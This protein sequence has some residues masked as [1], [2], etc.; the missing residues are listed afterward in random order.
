[1]KR[2]PTPQQLTA[3]TTMGEHICVDAGAGSGK[4][5]VLVDRIVHLLRNGVPL[6]QIVAITFTR[7]AAAEMR[8]R[9]RR[10]VHAAADPNDPA[11]MT[12]WRELEYQVESARIT[13]IDSFCAGLL[14]E[15]ALHLGIDPDFALLADAEIGLLRG[16]TAARAIEALLESGD[17]PAHRLAEEFGAYNLIDFMEETL[18]SPAPLDRAAIEYAGLDATQLAARWQR[19]ADELERMRLTQFV[20][21]PDLLRLARDLGS[22]D[23]C[24]TDASDARES[25]RQAALGAIATIQ[26]TGN[27]ETVRQAIQALATLSFRGGS[28]KSWTPES[29]FQQVKALCEEAKEIAKDFDSIESDPVIEARAAQL[30]L[31]VVHVYQRVTAEF[32]VAKTRR[33]AMDFPDL[34]SRTLDMLATRDDVRERVAR[35]I[36][37]LLVDEF[38]DT[39]HA[40][41]DL[42]VRLSRLT[43]Q[44]GAEL[45]VVGDAKQ[46]IYRFRSA[47]VEVFDEARKRTG[48]TLPLDENFRSVP[49]IIAFINDFFARSGLLSAVEPVFHR[50]VARRDPA[51]ETRVQFLVPPV[52]PD[53]AKANAETQ[54][55]REA[56]LIASRLAQMCGPGGV[57]VFDKN[58]R[59]LRPA[60][61]GDV[62]I[63]MRKSTNVEIYDAALRRLGIPSVVVEGSGYY[64]RQEVLDVHNLFAAALDPW[65]EFALAAFLRGP[66]GGV[67]DDALMQ[68]TRERG[69]ADA[70]QRGDRPAD[71]NQ[72]RRLDAARGLLR[73]VWQRRE[74]PLAALVRHVLARTGFEA[75]LLPQF[76]G[77]QKAGNLRKLVDLAENFSHTGRATLSAFTVYLAAVARRE[78]REGDADLLADGDG[79]V[80]LMTIH[81][82]KGLEFPIVVVADTAAKPGGSRGALVCVRH[83]RHGVAA[84]AHGATGEIEKPRFAQLLHA[85]DRDEAA[86][87]EARV[88]YVAMTRARDHLLIAVPTGGHKGTWANTIDSQLSV[89]RRAHNDEVQGDGWTARVVRDPAPAVTDRS[90]DRPSTELAMNQLESQAAAIDPESFPAVSLPISTLLNRLFGDSSED[91]ARPPTHDRRGDGKALGNAAHALMERWDFHSDPP[92]DAVVREFCPRVADRGHMRAGLLESLSR[93][94]KSVAFNTLLDAREVRREVPFVWRV[95][96]VVLRGK[97][98][99]LVNGNCLIDYKTGAFSVERHRRYEAQLQLYAAAATDAGQPVSSA[100]VVYLESGRT[101]KVDLSV[102][103]IERVVSQAMNALARKPA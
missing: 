63:L 83:H 30:T 25:V 41:L 4:T 3:I 29:A 7:K 75:I 69:L 20:T 78:L 38:Q 90:R 5:T 40:Q 74:M 39:N 96:G 49:K 1:M 56:D 88:L 103:A 46:S 34:L 97:I 55:E 51:R 71:A 84:V 15:N 54:R 47:E 57:T 61:F 80:A 53:D 77:A 37:H 79:A 11:S 36:R 101:E 26:A 59:T 98:D 13:T 28:K 87:E 89:S 10:E 18:K 67:S 62:A 94:K 102:S 99:V 58:T 85:V 14:R 81:K 33:N 95:N 8:E 35:G 52:E 22:F 21:N 50:L 93:L 24:C 86:A 91:T 68:L 100:F 19:D 44:A 23:G 16:E 42:A 9:L 12:K 43:N 31:D 76:H 17:A 32:S 72:A 65:N 60:Q 70:L 64:A 82:A 48:R 45:F 73:D 27:E 6:R 92:V 66:L 2:D